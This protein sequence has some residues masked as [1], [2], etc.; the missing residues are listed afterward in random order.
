MQTTERNSSCGQDLNTLLYNHE[1]KTI[2]GTQVSLLLMKEQQRPKLLMMSPWNPRTEGDTWKGTVLI[3]S[4]RGTKQAG[5]VL[6]VEI[7]G[8]D[9]R[10]M[11]TRV[12]KHNQMGE[13]M[14]IIKQGRHICLQFPN[15]KKKNGEKY[16]FI[17]EK[18]VWGINC[19]MQLIKRE[20]E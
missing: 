10:R 20:E 4:V 13:A 6:K 12:I 16:K 1:V 19:A 18:Q 5:R 17:K 7:R 2:N 9:G 3:Q 8:K 15:N 11:D 14:E